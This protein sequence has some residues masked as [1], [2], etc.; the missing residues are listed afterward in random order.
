MKNRKNRLGFGVDL[1]NR[2]VGVYIMRKDDFIDM[3]KRMVVEYSN[4]YIRV[5]DNVSS[6]SLDDVL[7]EEYTN[8]QYTKQATLSTPLKNDEKYCI[9]LD[10]KTK[11]IE[12][13]IVKYVD[14]ELR[15][16]GLKR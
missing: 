2:V 15:V 6:I 14:D 10:Q 8:T 5:N 7:V 13:Y 12:S 9:I 1:K 16:G 4:R 11:K 3:C